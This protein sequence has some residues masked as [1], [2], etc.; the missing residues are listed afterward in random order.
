MAVADEINDR[1]DR[2]TGGFIIKYFG[3]WDGVCGT[4]RL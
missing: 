4:Q 3:K 2:D 1:S